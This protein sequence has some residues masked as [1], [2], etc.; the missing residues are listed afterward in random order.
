MLTV[1][2]KLRRRY[3]SALAEMVPL[4]LISVKSSF[5]LRVKPAGLHSWDAHVK[6]TLISSKQLKSLIFEP[7]ETRARRGDRS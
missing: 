2:G 3:S 7:M 5:F 6:L 4:P 1:E